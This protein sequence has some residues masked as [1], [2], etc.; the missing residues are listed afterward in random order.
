M[1]ERGE[2]FEEEKV[3]HHHHY[4]PYHGEVIFDGLFVVGTKF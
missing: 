3:R 4:H 2:K 1:G